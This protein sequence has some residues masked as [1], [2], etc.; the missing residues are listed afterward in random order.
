MLAIG[1]YLTVTRENGSAGKTYR[2][3]SLYQHVE[4]LDRSFLTQEF[5]FDYFSA[6]EA[7]QAGLVIPT[8][9]LQRRLIEL[10]GTAQYRAL[11]NPQYSSIS[12][13]N[14]SSYQNRTEFV[15]DV[16]HASIYNTTR[17]RALKKI[18]ANHFLG[19]PIEVNP[20]RLL[21]GALFVPDVRIT[22][23]AI[24]IKTATFT[25][26]ADYLEEHDL[27]DA[28]FEVFP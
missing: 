6:V 8:R 20:I 10:V 9:A 18:A 3:F 7:L 4:Q 14:N 21:L 12:N 23:H 15:L 28:R 13:P 24:D 5:S 19:Q 17:P 2:L 26:I 27:V 11:H 16:L 22:D 1:I 25:T